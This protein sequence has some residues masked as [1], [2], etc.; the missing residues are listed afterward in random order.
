MLY[1]LAT[2]QLP[3]GRPA[4]VAELRGR[5]YRDPVPP[6]ALGPAIPEWL[7]EIVLRCLEVDARD[8]YASAHDLAVA[9]SSPGGVPLTERAERTRRAGLATL[10]RR[11]L[12]AARFKP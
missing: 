7:Q 1:E 12:R 4:T 9:L 3:F 2:G 11:R 5:L 8:R 6:R 10:A